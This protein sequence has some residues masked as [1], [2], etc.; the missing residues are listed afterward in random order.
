MENEIFFGHFQYIRCMALIHDGGERR[1]PAVYR[2]DMTAPDGKGNVI[3]YGAGLPTDEISARAFD[4]SR[5]IEAAQNNPLLASKSSEFYCGNN[6]AALAQKRKINGNAYLFPNQPARISLA[7][8][9]GVKY[10]SCS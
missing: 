2:H 4:E 6:C 10:F 7:V 9:K 3:I 8:R 1:T 5:Y